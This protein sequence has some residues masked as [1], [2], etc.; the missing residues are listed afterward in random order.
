MRTNSVYIFNIFVMVF[1]LSLFIL[2][3]LV[4]TGRRTAFRGLSRSFFLLNFSYLLPILMLVKIKGINPNPP[5][6]AH[7]PAYMYVYYCI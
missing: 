6:H 5:P 1:L 7:A 2:L 3:G 4:T